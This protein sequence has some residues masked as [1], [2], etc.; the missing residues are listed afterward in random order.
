MDWYEKWPKWPNRVTSVMMVVESIYVT[1]RH[2][3]RKWLVVV[4]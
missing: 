1:I 2:S 4:F 3:L